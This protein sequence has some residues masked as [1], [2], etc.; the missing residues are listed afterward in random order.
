MPRFINTELESESDT[1][2]MAELNLVL[3]LIMNKTFYIADNF[4]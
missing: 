3:V 4:F 1:E 2:L